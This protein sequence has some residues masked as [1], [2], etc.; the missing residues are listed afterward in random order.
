MTVTVALKRVKKPEP[1]LALLDGMREPFFSFNI[2][3]CS[4]TTLKKII[5]PTLLFIVFTKFANY[6]YCFSITTWI[7]NHAGWER[8]TVSLP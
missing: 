3:Q 1:L 2:A 7:I 5:V 4:F 6:Y 8:C